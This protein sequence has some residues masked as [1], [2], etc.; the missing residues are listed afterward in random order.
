MKATTIELKSSHVSLIS[1]PR[2][3]ADVILAAAGSQG[4]DVGFGSNQANGFL[5]VVNG[6]RRIAGPLGNLR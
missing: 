4:I 6:V 5:Y 1:H 2:E 3:I